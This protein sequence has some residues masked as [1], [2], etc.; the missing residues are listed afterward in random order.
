MENF[1]SPLCAY[2]KTFGLD[3]RSQFNSFL[4]N[5]TA[6]NRTNQ[7]SNSRAM[8][9]N[10]LSTQNAGLWADTLYPKIPRK[11]ARKKWRQICDLDDTKIAYSVSLHPCHRRLRA[12]CCKQDEHWSDCATNAMS[13]PAPS[14]WFGVS[15]I[16]RWEAKFFIRNPTNEVCRPQ[17]GLPAINGLRDQWHRHSA[18]TNA[19]RWWR[20]GLSKSMLLISKCVFSGP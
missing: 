12:F 17:I 10:F 11:S 16:L 6:R 4:Q 14:R 2:R 5:Q 7:T 9:I 3:W 18:C 19:L 15:N 8:K 1:R 13:M 20:R